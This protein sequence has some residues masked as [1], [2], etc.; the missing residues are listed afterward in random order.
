MPR[1]K[2]KAEPPAIV[3]DGNEVR[4]PLEV[5]DDLMARLLTAEGAVPDERSW[6]RRLFGGGR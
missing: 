6:G 5:F 3:R 4:M 2:D 1:R